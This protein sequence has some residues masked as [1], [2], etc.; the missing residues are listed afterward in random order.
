MFI[1]L[2]CVRVHVHIY[3]GMWESLCAQ[4]SRPR[5]R[6]HTD[7]IHLTDQTQ[8]KTHIHAHAAGAAA[9][10]FGAEGGQV[11]V[12]G[13]RPPRRDAVRCLVSIPSHWIIGPMGSLSS[14]PARRLD[15]Q[16][17]RTST[18]ICMYTYD[19]YIHPHSVRARSWIIFAPYV[20]G[21]L[22]VGGRQFT[23]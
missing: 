20:M 14:H 7:P 13:R 17:H 2:L 9:V 12:P 11:G 15:P 1:R 22:E 21:R 4:F 16:N 6:A 5:I 18:N 10:P 8:T 19:P 23:C 3:V